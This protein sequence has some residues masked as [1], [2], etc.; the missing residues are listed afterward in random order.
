MYMLLIYEKHWK[1][2]QWEA[3]KKSHHCLDL[4]HKV[5][6]FKTSYSVAFGLGKAAVE[7]LLV[8]EFQCG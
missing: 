8:H 4:T 2:H 5:S 3:L 7:L 6:E 1:K